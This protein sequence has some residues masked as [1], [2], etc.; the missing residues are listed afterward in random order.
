VDL[1]KLIRVST[2]FILVEI[3]ALMVVTYFPQIVLFIPHLF[4]FK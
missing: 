1:I 2:P 4:G 3:G